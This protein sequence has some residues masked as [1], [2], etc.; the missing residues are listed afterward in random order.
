MKKLALIG[1]AGFILSAGSCQHTAVARPDATKLVCAYEPDAP[2]PDAATG[3]VSD[4]QDAAY[5]YELRQSWFDCHSAVTWLRD[6]FDKL[7]D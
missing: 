2:A 6:W 7:P 3:E 4:E 1:I 5:K